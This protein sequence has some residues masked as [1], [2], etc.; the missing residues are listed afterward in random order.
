M[1]L[2]SRHQTHPAGATTNSEAGITGLR[3][4]YPVIEAMETHDLP[5][6][7]HGEVTDEHCDIFDR[8]KGL[9]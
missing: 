2:R 3:A 9:Y 5:L 4:L 8:E 6:L 7:V 1:P